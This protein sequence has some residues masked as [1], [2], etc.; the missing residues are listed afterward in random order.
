MLNLKTA[1]AIPKE[2]RVKVTKA[3]VIPKPLRKPIIKNIFQFL[4]MSL[5]TFEG[6][7]KTIKVYR[8]NA[9]TWPIKAAK[10]GFCG[11]VCS[12]AVFSKA[13]VIAHNR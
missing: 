3:S 4:L 5:N 11:K 7:L 8:P 9:T 12:I 2:V 13:G 6:V 1:V 10:A